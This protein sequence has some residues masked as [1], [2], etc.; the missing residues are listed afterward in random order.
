M[1]NIQ[2]KNVDNNSKNSGISLGATIKFKLPRET[3]NG[4]LPVSAKLC[5]RFTRVNFKQN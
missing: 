3:S 5:E 2:K 4:R 1:S